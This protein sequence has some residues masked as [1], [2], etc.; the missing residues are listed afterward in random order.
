MFY[1]GVLRWYYKGS[2]KFVLCLIW[3][4]LCLG[5]EERLEKAHIA[6]YSFQ[7]LPPSR[8]KKKRVLHLNY[9]C[10]LFDLKLL[11]RVS[12]SNILGFHSRE[13]FYTREIYLLWREHC[14]L[15]VASGQR[16]FQIHSAKAFCSFPCEANF[17]IRPLLLQ[18]F[19]QNVISQMTNSDS[20][21]FIYFSISV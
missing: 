6:T 7:S 3:E 19:V 2:R 21:F 1:L 4:P 18:L 10:V 13:L 12:M 11:I 20:S 9:L 16:T 8:P 5:R 15:E 17:M 14:P